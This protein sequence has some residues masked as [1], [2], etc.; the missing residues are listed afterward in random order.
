MS[1]TDTLSSYED[2]LQRCRVRL[3]LFDNRGSDRGSPFV[4]LGSPCTRSFFTSLSHF[5]AA[6]ISGQIRY[7]AAYKKEKAV[8]Q[9]SDKSFA[10]RYRAEKRGTK[11]K[12]KTGCHFKNRP[13][14]QTLHFSLP[15][16]FLS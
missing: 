2:I 7:T 15:L 3:F 11:Y 5:V 13:N 1:Q 16:L 10:F 6:D 12:A 9:K 14:Y 8:L 4:S